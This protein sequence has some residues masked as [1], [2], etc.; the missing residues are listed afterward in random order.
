PDSAHLAS[1]TVTIA[2]GLFTGDVLS[3]NGV[4]SGLIGGTNI[5]ASYTPPGG[6]GSPGVLSLTGSDTPAHYQQVLEA[7]QFASTRHNPTN[8]GANPSRTIDWVANDGTGNSATAH[9]IVNI[10]AVNDAPVL[11]NVSASK[12][13]KQGDPPLTLSAGATASDLDNQHLVGATVTIAGGLLAGD[14]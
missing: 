5:T 14:L 2:S 6:I 8:F 1:A 11:A 10:T 9:T 7:I 4:T 12:S 13:Y 3:V